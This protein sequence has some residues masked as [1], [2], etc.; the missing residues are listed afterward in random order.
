VEEFKMV[1]MNLENRPETIFWFSDFSRTLNF[2]KAPADESGDIPKNAREKWRPDPH[3]KL[4]ESDE[5]EN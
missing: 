5:P 3:N 4:A 1:K 2:G